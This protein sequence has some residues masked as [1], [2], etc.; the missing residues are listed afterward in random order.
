MVARYVILYVINDDNGVTLDRVTSNKK[1]YFPEPQE[2][3]IDRQSGRFWMLFMER[4]WNRPWSDLSMKLSPKTWSEHS[5]H[6]MTKM[7]IKILQTIVKY[8]TLKGLC[9]LKIGTC[10]IPLHKD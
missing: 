8:M 3:N 10:H 1:E 2:F 5:Q 7:V 9:Q 4:F 6:E